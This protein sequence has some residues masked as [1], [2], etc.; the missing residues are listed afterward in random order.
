ML[1]L[2]HGGRRARTT[3]D[4]EGGSGEGRVAEDLFVDGQLLGEVVHADDTFED[5]WPFRL[6]RGI[7]DS[8]LGV[9]LAAP[10]Q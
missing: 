10:C 4:S 1:L 3:G 2:L 5:L 7:G 9:L 6:R 8:Q